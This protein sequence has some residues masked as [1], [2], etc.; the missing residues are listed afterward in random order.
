MGLYLRSKYVFSCNYCLLVF[1]KCSITLFS[2]P[3]LALTDSLDKFFPRRLRSRQLP[4]YNLNQYYF[5][6]CLRRLLRKGYFRI[7][8]IFHYSL[9]TTHQSLTYVPFT[10]YCKNLQIPLNNNSYNYCKCLRV[11]S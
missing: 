7:F 8:E 5:A 10:R 11:F 9:Y 2:E 3:T 1:G 4:L 6:S